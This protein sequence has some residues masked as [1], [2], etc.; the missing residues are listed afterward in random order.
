MTTWTES[1]QVPVQTHN[2]FT[3]LKKTHRQL[4]LNEQ[5]IVITIGESPEFTIIDHYGMMVGTPYKSEATA[6]QYLASCKTPPKR[7][8]TT[9][10]R[11]VGSHN[12]CLLWVKEREVY[13]STDGESFVQQEIEP[14][15]FWIQAT[16]GQLHQLAA[17]DL[18]AAELE[19]QRLASP[20]PSEKNSS[21]TM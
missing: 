21:F 18:S 14:I 13:E 5:G 9:R 20:P 12:G 19:L 16:D 3:L 17:T 7:F 15:K 4:A 6:R 10:T 2:G 8:S 11:V 1:H